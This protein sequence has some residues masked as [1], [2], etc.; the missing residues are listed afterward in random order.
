MLLQCIPNF[1]SLNLDHVYGQVP[2]PEMLELA[3]LPLFLEMAGIGNAAAPLAMRPFLAWRWASSKDM[4]SMWRRRE[5]MEVMISFAASGFLSRKD[6]AWSGLSEKKMG[7]RPCA[8]VLS[9]MSALR[10]NA[11]SKTETE[12]SLL[13]N[14]FW[15]LQAPVGNP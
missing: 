14:F 3:G 10:L 5:L 12:L 13:K 8:N 11:P 4:C 2:E 7:T 9:N 6:W 15:T 1:S